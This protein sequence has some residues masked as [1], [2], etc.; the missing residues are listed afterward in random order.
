MYLWDRR[1]GR[2][3]YGLVASVIVTLTR[4][5]R[6]MLRVFFL[7]VVLEKATASSSRPPVGAQS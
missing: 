5:S 4:G 2:V 6:R 1:W 3:R 7:V